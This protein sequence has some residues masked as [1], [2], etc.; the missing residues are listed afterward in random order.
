MVHDHE[1]ERPVA[2]RPHEVGEHRKRQRQRPDLFLDKARRGLIVRPRWCDQICEKQQR[3][4]K[5]PEAL[6]THVMTPS[7]GDWANSTNE[8]TGDDP[9][10]SAHG[11]ISRAHR[12]IA[13]QPD[14]REFVESLIQINPCRSRGV[15]YGRRAPRQLAL[16]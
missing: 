3:S 8:A 2:D 14:S 15:A 5:A 11:R 6:L 16:T 7:T 12:S 4:D 9:A 13:H 1:R 10:D